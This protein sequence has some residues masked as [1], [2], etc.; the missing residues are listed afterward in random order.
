M[1]DHPPPT[2]TDKRALTSA[3]NGR[4]SR[5]PI[6]PAGKAAVRFNAIKHGIHARPILIT[7]GPSAEDAAELTA[8]YAQFHAEF[9]PVGIAEEL[10]LERLFVT[11]WRMRR[12][13]HGETTLLQTDNTS[14]SD[15]D[16]AAML[17]R[18][19]DRPTDH[20]HAAT[21]A[22][23]TTLTPTN[24]TLNL[25]KIAHVA[26]YESPLE[27][28]FYRA[29]R[30]LLDLQTRRHLRESRRPTL[31]QRR[32]RMKRK[33]K[34]KCK[35]KPTF[36]LSPAGGGHRQRRGGIVSPYDLRLTTY[37]SPV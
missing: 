26:R 24:P 6:T 27:K 11:Y 15:D 21:P 4:R 13:L 18:V 33:K 5:G 1:T 10:L 20:D 30:A 16:I 25:D 8:L 17:R 37:D 14:H 34:Q 9:E 31:P 36:T 29:L 7:H 32:P 22:M 2:R 3:A 28:A 23:P 35:N 19:L 12:I